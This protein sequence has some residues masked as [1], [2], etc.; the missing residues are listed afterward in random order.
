M[1]NFIWNI[2]THVAVSRTNPSQLKAKNREKQVVEKIRLMFSESC[3]GESFLPS[4]K[5]ARFPAILG[6]LGLVDALLDLCLCCHRAF[7]CV[8]SASEPKL[9]TS[10]KA[11]CSWVRAHLNPV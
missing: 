6:T 8:T 10:Y 7:S 9:P 4:L 5:P 2:K 3:R 1:R 11:T